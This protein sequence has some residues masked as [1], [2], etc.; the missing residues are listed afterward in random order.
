MPLDPVF[1]Q[2]LP[3]MPPLVGESDTVEQVR[4]RFEEIAAHPIV[5]DAAPGVG[6]VRQITVT[7]AAGPIDARVYRPE[8][9]QPAPTVVYFHGGGYVIG[10]LDTHD[11]V[12]REIC[13]Q[14]GAVVLSV[15]YRLAPE[16]PFPSGLEDCLA[17]TRW[18][19]GHIDELGGDPSR[20]AV[21]GDSAGG[22]FA[23]VTAQEL[24]VA[25]HA[26]ALAAQLLIYPATDVSRDYPSREAFN[27]GYFLDSAA[28][29]LFAEAYVTDLS[30]LPDPRMS[31]ILHPKL[32]ALPPTVVIT[33]EYDPLRDQGEAYADAV[34]GSGVEVY[35]RRCEGLI[36]G[37]AHFGPF[38]PA[39]AAAVADSCAMLRAA[40]RL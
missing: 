2:L 3:T 40:L 36:H 32:A 12:C 38:V 19:A 37:F 26:P 31:P 35:R 23:A 39:A 11:L 14:V 20:L 10:S 28:L 16:H 33:A 21:A 1:E 29:E 6:S 8:R 34:E 13:R 9:E 18:A 7:G 30:L 17:A 5:V 15:D 4:Q 22:T 25:G 27:E 24:A